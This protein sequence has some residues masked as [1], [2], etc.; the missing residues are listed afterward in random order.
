MLWNANLILIEILNSGIKLLV[1]IY[2][3]YLFICTLLEN[4][5]CIQL[6]SIFRAWLIRPTRLILAITLKWGSVFMILRWRESSSL[7]IPMISK[8]IDVGIYYLC[9]VKTDRKWNWQME[10]CTLKRIFNH[11]LKPIYDLHMYQNFVL[12]LFQLHRYLYAWFHFLKRHV[13]SWPFI[14]EDRNLN[15]SWEAIVLS[16]TSSPEL[17]YYLLF[18]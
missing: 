5:L 11:N 13:V 12:H 6:T 10:F 7:T 3:I 8:I 1:H 4:Q 14:K 15:K 18:I 9:I 17:L 16:N 2:N